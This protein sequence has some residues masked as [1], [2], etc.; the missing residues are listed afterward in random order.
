LKPA[1]R[2]AFEFNIAERRDE[3]GQRLEQRGL[4]G[5][6][7]PDQCHELAYGQRHAGIVDDGASA[8]PD[9]EV[10]CGQQGRGHDG[11]PSS[12]RRSLKI[13]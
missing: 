9:R 6:I 8:E 2:L 1:C 12:Q 4:A 10:F 3:T 7:R 5:A 13:I 11:S